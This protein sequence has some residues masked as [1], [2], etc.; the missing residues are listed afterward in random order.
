MT[1]L[2]Q[3]E[4]AE[5]LAKDPKAFLLDVRTPAEY[6]DTHIPN[7]TLIDIYRS[8][9][10]IEELEKLDKTRHYYVYCRSGK[11]SGQACKLMNQLGI[12]NAFN[13]EGGILEWEGEVE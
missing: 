5:A 12:E 6:E 11:R 7:A 10:F 2:T 13:L 9:E 3:E 8:Q 1:D 4:W